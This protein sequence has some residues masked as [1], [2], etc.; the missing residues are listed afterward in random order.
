MYAKVVM[1]QSLM[2]DNLK[3]TQEHDVKGG[4]HSHIQ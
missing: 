4:G 1:I 3:P 2:E